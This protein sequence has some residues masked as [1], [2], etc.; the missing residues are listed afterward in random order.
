MRSFKASFEA[1]RPM[2]VNGQGKERVVCRELNMLDGTT[3]RVSPDIQRSQIKC[4]PVGIWHSVS[5]RNDGNATES[6]VVFCLTPNRHLS[7][8]AIH[9]QNF[10]GSCE[11]ERIRQVAAELAPGVT[12]VF[13]KHF[14]WATDKRNDITTRVGFPVAT[15]DLAGDYHDP[16]TLQRE[17]VPKL[18]DLLLLASFAATHRCMC[19]GWKVSDATGRTSRYDRGG[20][21]RPARR[22]PPVL[23]TGLVPLVYFQRFLSQAWPVFQTSPYADAIRSAVYS[24]VPTTSMT[25]ESRFLSLF[26]A[27][28]EL[29]LTFRR[30]NNKEF[31]LSRAQWGAVE[32]AIKATIKANLGSADKEVRSMLYDNLGGLNRVPLRRVVEQFIAHVQVDLTDLWPVFAGEGDG[33]GAIRNKLVHGDLDSST[34]AGTISIAAQ[35]LTWTVERIVLTLLSWPIE[36]SEVRKDLLARHA[37][38]MQH[39]AGAR[40][41]VARTIR[42]KP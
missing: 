12:L 40:A 20:I 15:T 4:E 33:L 30:L 31:I 22:P 39:L 38:D 7:V 23:D 14:G 34:S 24:V 41:E 11:V 25:V 2:A 29:V 3:Q 35:H 13:D 28:E 37:V 19:V 5:P 26:T 1:E 18:D 36:R 17:L 9:S 27:L 8:A 6:H 21:G 16:L 10:D 32:P 42:S